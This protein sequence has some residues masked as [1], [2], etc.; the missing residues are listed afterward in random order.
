MLDLSRGPVHLSYEQGSGATTLAL[1]VAR[2]VLKSGNRVKWLSRVLPDGERTSQILW[3]LTES[4]LEKFLAME[5]K[6]NLNESFKIIKYLI[7]GLDQTDIVIIDDWCS[8]TGRASK[9]DIEGIENIVSMAVNSKILICSTA[10]ENMNGK[11]GQWKSRGG[12]RID[13]ITRKNFLTRSLHNNSRI[14]KDG[15]NEMFI[16]IIGTGVE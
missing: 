10:Y 15:N 3:D 9:E 2:D 4:E 6:E 12:K 14:L 13:S 8:K 5:I 7:K 1:S 11:Q 16:K